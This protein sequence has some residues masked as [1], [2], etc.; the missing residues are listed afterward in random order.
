[1]TDTT[2]SPGT[3]WQQAIEGL[4]APELT[5]LGTLVR[6]LSLRVGLE[7]LTD[8]GVALLVTEAMDEAISQLASSHQMQQRLERE[9]WYQRHG[10]EPPGPLP[11]TLE[12]VA[13]TSID[14]AFGDGLGAEPSIGEQLARIRFALTLDPACADAYLIQGAVEEEARQ[15]ER[16]RSAY[17]RAMHLAATRLGEE[18]FSPE[19]RREG[20]VHFWGAIET[21]GY[22][23]ARAALGLVLWRQE[24]LAEAVEHFAG[25]IELNPNDNQGIRDFLLCC[26]LELG[27][28]RQLGHALK[29]HR[30]YRFDTGKEENRE[31]CW[32][33]T[34]AVWLFRKE[35]APAGKP[36]KEEATDILHHAFL[37]N[38]YVPMFLLEPRGLPGLDEL[39][40]Y[41]QGSPTE[42]ALYVSL[43]RKG[44]Q[45]TPGAFAWLEQMAREQGLL[46]G[47][48]GASPFAK[49]TIQVRPPREPAPSWWP[50]P[51]NAGPP[52]H[53]RPHPSGRR[54]RKP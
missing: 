9:G 19:A 4:E 18:A 16:A 36:P 3:S 34:Y 51:P 38:R 32:W 14:H 2:E 5:V 43:A 47:A 40:A 7:A 53:R 46:P 42:A 30:Y 50:D 37:L 29:H 17:E 8:P 35:G 31:S 41:A 23:R 22:M 52:S 11:I 39:S 15:W 1:M 27:D 6:D 33:D 54:Q 49:I 12:D 20:R 44:W 10:S 26:L 48:D 25:L 24:K 28:D 13:Q 21:R 45:K